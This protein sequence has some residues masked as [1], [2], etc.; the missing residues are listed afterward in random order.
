MANLVL[1]CLR[2][3]SA[4]RPVLLGSASART[5]YTISFA[6]VLDEQTGRGYQRRFN[7]Q[8]SLDFRRYIQRTGSATIPLTFNLRARVDGAWR[9][10]DLPTG[11]AAL[12]V[13]TNSRVLAQVDCQHRLGYLSDIDLDLPFM[14]FIEL[15]AR[16]E[17]EIFGIINGKA[18]GLS[19]S[20]LD[21]HD[22]QLCED[23]ATERPELLV[24]LFL[25]NEVTSPWYRR[26]DLGGNPVSGLDRRASLRTVQKAVKV[27]LRRTKPSVPMSAEQAA[28]TVHDFWVAVAAVLPDAF[29][30][31]RSYLVTKGIGVYALMELAADIVCEQPGKIPD[32]ATFTASLAD[33]ATGFDWSTSGPLKG[34]GG[35]G[36]VSEAL[37]LVRDARRRARLKVAHG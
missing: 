17:M 25:K 8:H 23:L 33:F 11:M 16:E 30:K 31:P 7:A 9:L 14:S 37:R 20:L 18:K 4:G 32:T 24:A 26:L 35:E 34:L 13:D 27:F 12:H 36:G 1:N 29:A 3:M 6:D 19:R 2:G 22:A 5:L 21:F 10:I 28:Q 15:D